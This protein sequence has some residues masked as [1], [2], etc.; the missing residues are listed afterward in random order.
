[1]RALARAPRQKRFDEQRNGAIFG[2]A[3]GKR[4]RRRPSC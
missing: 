4:Y 2:V 3:W 1:M